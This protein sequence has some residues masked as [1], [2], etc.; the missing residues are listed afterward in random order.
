MH[1]PGLHYTVKGRRPTTAAGWEGKAH[2]EAELTGHSESA[3]ALSKANGD[4]LK[5]TLLGLAILLAPRFGVAPPCRPGRAVDPPAP[6]PRLQLDA[7]QPPRVDEGTSQ[8]GDVSS[9]R[10][11]SEERAF[12]THS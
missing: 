6:S 4:L 3:S 8:A 11:T 9:E 7:R 5:G 2:L 10:R 12:T 1:Q